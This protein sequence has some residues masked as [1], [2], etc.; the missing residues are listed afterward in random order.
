VE[1]LEEVILHEGRA[2]VLATSSLADDRV[3]ILKAGD[4]FVVLDRHGDIQNLDHSP[5]GLYWGDTRFLSEFV[6]RLGNARPLLLSSRVTKDNTALIVDM[7]NP[8]LAARAGPAMKQDKTLSIWSA[9][10]CS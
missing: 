2:Y 10:R 9:P 3:Q 5:Q 6:I 7:T 4:E 1:E 8:P